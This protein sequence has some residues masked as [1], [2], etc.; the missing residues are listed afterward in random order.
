MK[1]KKGIIVALSIAGA[2][3]VSG[4]AIGIVGIASFHG[5]FASLDRHEYLESPFSF[6]E[7]VSKVTIS[8]NIADIEFKH[9]ENDEITVVCE[10]MKDA[11]HIV[12]ISD[13]TL[14]INSTYQSIDWLDW[15]R[16]GPIL[17]NMTITIGLPDV[18]YSELSVSSNTGDILFTDGFSFNKI[19]VHTDT[20]SISLQN[21][22]SSDVKST[23]S[24][25]NISLL[26]GAADDIDIDSS[27][28]NVYLEDVSCSSLVAHTSTGN[29]MIKSVIASADM[30]LTSSTGDV[31]FDHSDAANI[32]V[33]TSTGNI[34]GTLLSA[35]TFVCSSSTGNV[36]VPSGLTGGTFEAH[37][38]T[39]D[40]VISII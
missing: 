40:I 33:D 38:S 11:P 30:E 10:E 39:G 2:L 17:R 36:N 14:T 31:N 24:T 15:F 8:E 18:A 13:G 6:T 27:T 28:G 5:N 16:Y 9:S 22:V 19:D 23:T 26:N 3:V 29:T 12:N 25:G 1:M 34:T 7:S 4:I 32:S 20:G 37:T 35:K 21:F